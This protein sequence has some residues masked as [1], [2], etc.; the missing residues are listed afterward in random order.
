MNKWTKLLACA[1]LAYTVMGGAAA[2][3]TE[4][5]SV[6]IE[7]QIGNSEIVVNGESMTV[8]KPYLSK[9]NVTLVPM[10]VITTAFGAD[11]SWEQST[12][13]AKL[14]YEGKTI[15]LQINNKTVLVNG[16]KVTLEAA[17]ENK[18]G[19]TM[20]P[21]R[22]ITENFGA[23]V[24]YDAA[25]DRITIRKGAGTDPLA[26]TIAE[27]AAQDDADYERIGDSRFG[28]SIE[29]RSDLELD[30]QSSDGTLVDFYE[31]NG[32]YTLSVI[33]EENQPSMSEQ[34]LMR[35]LKEWAYAPTVLDQS[36][37]QEGGYAR[38]IGKYSYG[39]YEEYRLYVKDDVHYIISLGTTEENFKD[40][41]K[42][43]AL[44][45][46]LDSFET[47]FDASDS[48]YK[49]ISNNF[50]V[51]DTSDYGVKFKVPSDWTEDYDSTN[52]YQIHSN[53][54]G[55][56]SLQVIVN[57][58]DEGDT[59]EA[60]AKRTEGYYDKFYVE[61]NYKVGAPTKIQL[62]GLAALV[63]TNEFNDGSAWFKEYEIF[64]ADAGY[65]YYFALQAPK[66]ISTQE[67]QHLKGA[68]AGSI[69]ID[70]SR[71]NEDIGYLYDDWDNM[72][73]ESTM[74][75]SNAAK[76]LTAEVPEYWTSSW[77]YFEDDD[78][79]AY[80]FTGGQYL[81]MTMDAAE[82]TL[83]EEKKIFLEGIEED[84]ALDPTLV[85]TT[86]TVQKFG[87]TVEKIEVTGEIEEAPGSAT[88]YFFQ[89]GD[90]VYIILSYL[91]DV[92]RTELLQSQV[93]AVT[94]SITLK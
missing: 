81:I 8:A 19:T 48:T 49:D 89:K 79:L 23:K 54:D 31:L 7:L 69:E 57:S 29:Y 45:A 61:G 16:E 36:Y 44:T 20:V 75:I 90:K 80:M 40:K 88:F 9:T 84:K 12:Q 59:L 56:Q 13:T 92:N 78:T 5:T 63:R 25:E 85:V 47:T 11:L 62:N 70:T 15:T 6:D 60:W 77:S 73:Y 91:L 4:A 17:P 50:E 83:A 33:V 2:S 37:N 38:V 71:M 42:W 68:I 53:D 93:Q 26:G 18:A 39:D 82:T 55:T 74:S 32:D 64:A 52:D 65:K 66:D 30:Y 86:S 21:I 41:Q 27:Q 24:L 14:T 46:I 34:S 1:A 43:D 3:A 72:D 22:F 87:V 35:A 51:I 67:W 94:E 28:W 10:R 76:T 58:M